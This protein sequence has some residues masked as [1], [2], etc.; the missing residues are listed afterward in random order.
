MKYGK[1]TFF[2]LIITFLV[3]INTVGV[4]FALFLENNNANTQKQTYKNEYTKLADTV[5]VNF[6]KII[7]YQDQD[8]IDG[9][10]KSVLAQYANENLNLEFRNAQ[11]MLLYS[12]FFEPQVDINKDSVEILEIDSVR[13]I[14]VSSMICD[15]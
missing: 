3:F 7:Q 1:K 13:C 9:F 10:L 4:L 6:N 11:D 5:E 15:G 12:S 2:T 8:L 14:V